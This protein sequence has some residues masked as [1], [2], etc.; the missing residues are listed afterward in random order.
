MRILAFDTSTDVGSVALTEGDE[1]VTERHGTVVARHGEALLPLVKESLAEAGWTLAD[2]E[3][4][5]VGVGPGSFTGTRIGMATA[6]GLVLATGVPL[7]GVTSLEAIARAAAAELDSEDVVAAL[8]AKRG[9]VF[10][11]RFGTAPVAP[12]EASPAAA[13]EVL[14]GNALVAVGSGVRAYP[15]LAEGM[16][17]AS[18]ELDRPRAV[19]LARIGRERFVAEGA[20]HDG[21]EPL[22]VRGSDA[23]LPEQAQAS[24]GVSGVSG[25]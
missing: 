17:L 1:L 15:Q 10:A 6:K 16:R 3:L 19:W 24:S 25:L 9:K 4:L 7:V 12:F 22:Y 20:A 21:L 18:P 8:D 23:K 11:A 5:V 13:R 2:V 14:A